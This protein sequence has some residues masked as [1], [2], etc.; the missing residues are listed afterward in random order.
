M[1]KNTSVLVS[2]SLAYDYIMDFDGVFTDYI[3]PEKLHTL[4]LSFM[5]QN[6]KQHYGGTAGNIAYSLALLGLRS[7]ILSRFGEDAKEYRRRCRAQGIDCSVA[8]VA[9]GRTAT[10]WIMTD[11]KDNQITAFH[12]GVM[13]TPAWYAKEWKKKSYALAIA[14]AGN[15]DD[16][17]AV[18]QW[19]AK[20]K[21]PFLFDPGQAVTFLK[22][23]EMLKLVRGSTALIVNDYE[24][25]VVLK[26]LGCSQ[27]Q[28]FALTSCLI[29][30][31]GERGS[32][33]E[34]KKSVTIA[35][36]PLEP[37][38]WNIPVVPA[39]KVVDP[40]GAGDAYRSGLIAGLV[41]GFS[42]EKAGQMGST[43]AVYAVEKEGTQEH[44]YTREQFHDRYGNEFIFKN[45]H[46]TKTREKAFERV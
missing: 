23:P 36:T 39:K 35:G 31:L 6:V 1:K 26:T 4:S 15:A 20:T 25:D 45:Q 30:T 28:L 5:V 17:L 8:T 33:I 13:F 38:V 29:T 2:G 7:T 19:C 22:Q 32:R 24:L 42:W 41:Q 10:A 43:A 9:T 3:L 40:T 27:Q 34:A 12:P 16:R 11:K 14:A 18:A 44:R 46:L 37:G 21:T